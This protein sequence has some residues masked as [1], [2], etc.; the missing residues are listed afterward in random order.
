MSNQQTVV[1]SNPVNRQR[2]GWDRRTWT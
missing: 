1:L 2:D